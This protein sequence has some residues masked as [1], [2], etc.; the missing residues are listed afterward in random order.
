MTKFKSISKLLLVIYR[1]I[2]I[3]NDEKNSTCLAL[4]IINFFA[5]LL[6]SMSSA[7]IDWFFRE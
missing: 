6:L 1:I 5:L 4:G 7:M 3:I 2:L